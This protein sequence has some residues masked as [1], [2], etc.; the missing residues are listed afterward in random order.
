MVQPTCCVVVEASG[1]AVSLTVTA[2]GFLPG[3]PL[4]L[5]CLGMEIRPKPLDLTA[6]QEPGLREAPRP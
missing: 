3:V 1:L 6:E 4:G 2:G 5:G